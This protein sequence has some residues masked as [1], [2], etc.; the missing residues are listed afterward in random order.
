MTEPQQRSDISIR[1][2]LVPQDVERSAEIWVSAL[3]ERDGS[4]DAPVMAQR[5]RDA[6]AEQGV[7]RFAVATAPRDGFAL[8]ETIPDEPTQAYLHYLAVDPAGTGGGVGSALLA[9]AIQHAQAAGYASLKL[10]VKTTNDRAVGLYV[11]AGF[12]AAGEPTPHATAGYPM[13]SYL[14]SLA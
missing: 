10:E 3:R 5:V 4:V 6:F 13:Q 1:Q 2:G 11:K 12:V 14:L 9:D 7:V 8:V